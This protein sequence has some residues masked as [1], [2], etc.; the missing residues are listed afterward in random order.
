MLYKRSETLSEILVCAKISQNAQP[1]STATAKIKKNFIAKLLLLG[2]AFFS[3]FPASA[4][5]RIFN[6]NNIFTDAELYDATSVSQTAIQAFLEKKNSVLARLSFQMNGVTQKSSEVIWNTAQAYGINPKFLLTKLEKEQGLLSRSTATEKALDWATGYGC[7]GGG[8][9]E[10]YRGF[11]AQLDA[12]ADT[13][14]IYTEKKD[15][16]SFKVGK[17]TKTYDSYV[18]TPQNQAT[19]NLY[20]YTPYVGASPELGISGNV[21][22][23]RLFW[24]IWHRYFSSQVYLDGQ[25]ITSGDTYWKIENNQKRRF[26]SKTV[27]LTDHTE[28]QAFTVGADVLNAYPDGPEIRF[29][30]TTLV[31]AQP[32]GQL[33]LLQNKTKRPVADDTIAL[34]L[35]PTLHIAATD[36]SAIQSTTEDELANY[37]LGSLIT[38]AVTYPAG[39]VFR[40]TAGTLWLVQDNLKLPLDSIVAQNRFP[41]ATPEALPAEF[42]N[43]PTGSPVKLVDGTFV[44]TDDGTYYL[45]TNGERMKIEDPAGAFARYFGPEKQSQALRISSAVLELHTAGELISY[46]D[47]TIAQTATTPTTPTPTLS[48]AA[49]PVAIEPNGFVLSAGQQV[50]I[51]ATYT[52]SGATTW[53]PG[54]VWLTITDRGATTRSFGAPEKIELATSVSTGQSTTFYATLTA[55]N[56]VAGA[57][58]LD[59]TLWANPTSPTQLATVSKFAIVKASVTAS[60]TK[61]TVPKTISNK[62]KPVTV[63]VQIKNTSPDEIWLSRKAAL[64]IYAPGNAVSPFYDKNDWI[65][66][67]VAAV[68]LNASKIKP[69]ETG[70]FTFTLDAR[71]VKAGEHTLVFFLKLLDR[72]KTVVLTDTASWTVPITVK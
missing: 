45:I 4:D 63:T 23:N 32:S 69:G 53:Q 28:S 29:A 16:F 12:A 68:P 10:K 6:P 1:M 50:Q 58:G 54:Q 36:A 30:N 56:G 62:A 24:R 39:K 42:Q 43:L 70:K 72:D 18:V 67:E 8:C 61:H 34:A 35:L 51:Q 40:D 26:S 21:G 25:V 52:N 57:Q 14:R 27:F 37:T 60:V 13:Q 33:Y 46:M 9:I 2:V 20:I 44:R 55:P 19:A 17:A 3:A 48:Y 59:Y 41:T 66:K 65:R 47:D 38:S 71:G 64:E 22:G 5:A 31:R 11:V 15:Q 7:F 49:S